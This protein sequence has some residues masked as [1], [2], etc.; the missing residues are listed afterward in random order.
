VSLLCLDHVSKR[1]PDGRRQVMVLAD[2]CFEVDAG[3]FVG[4]WGVR[5]SGKSTLLRVA[6]GDVLP[7]EGKVTFDG[8]DMTRISAD[9]R[10]RLHRHGGIGLLR[11]DWHTERNMP[12]IEHVALGLLSDGLSL[13]EAREPA[14]RALERVGIASCAHM[15]ID[16]LALDERVRVALAQLLIHE[17]RLLLVDDPAIMLRPSDGVALYE[18]LRGLAHEMRLAMVVVSEEL[19]PIRQASRM[20]SIDAGKLRAMDQPGTVLQFPERKAG[21]QGPNA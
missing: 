4:V 20:F 13:R 16:R 10:A 21:A 7:E 14:W 18:L 12:V 3:E 5:R 9:A 8:Q 1:Y 17:P 11:S 19:A 6:A 2:V 15:Q